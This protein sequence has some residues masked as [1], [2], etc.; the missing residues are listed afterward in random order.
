MLEFL[1]K[2]FPRDL[3]KLTP[4][5][6]KEVFKFLEATLDVSMTL[7]EDFSGSLLNHILMVMSDEYLW[8]E[9]PGAACLQLSA[10]TLL[11]N[12]GTLH[13]DDQGKI[14]GE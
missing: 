9:R 5:G 1:W 3:S 11:R 4:S 12:I 10:T 6:A 2:L 13:L 8:A 7:L 14:Y